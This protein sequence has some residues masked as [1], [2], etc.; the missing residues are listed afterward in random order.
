M[1]QARNHLGYSIRRQ[2]V[3]NSVTDFLEFLFPLETEDASTET[4]D[5]AWQTQERT[6]FAQEMNEFIC[7]KR[8]FR[9]LHSR[10]FTI[11]EMAL[12]EKDIVRPISSEKLFKVR[13]TIQPTYVESEKAFSGLGCFV[14]KVRSRFQDETLDAFMF[15]AVILNS[16]NLS[17]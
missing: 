13:T 6:A 17:K 12:F 9:G 8:G 11:K 1:Y 5:L 15:Y 10:K 7:N 4:R 16:G 3:W 14:T 2:N